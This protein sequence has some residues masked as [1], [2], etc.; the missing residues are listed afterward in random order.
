MYI[1]VNLYMIQYLRQVLCSYTLLSQLDKG[2]GG[3][4]AELLMCTYPLKVQARPHHETK[5]WLSGLVS[6]GRREFDIGPV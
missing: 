5:N 3:V 4:Q 1:Y 2:G 6:W